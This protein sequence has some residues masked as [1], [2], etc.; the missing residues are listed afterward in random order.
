M[1]GVKIVT[2]TVVALLYLLAIPEGFN[3]R[4]PGVPLR[5]RCPSKS[6]TYIAGAIGWLEI[7]CPT[8]YCSDTEYIAHLNYTGARVCLDP[9]TKWFKQVLKQLRSMNRSR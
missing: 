8:S 4:L 9:N 2:I 7:N 6:R 3:L 5:C 1:S